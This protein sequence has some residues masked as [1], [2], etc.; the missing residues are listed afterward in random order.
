VGAIAAARAGLIFLWDALR[1][2]AV[3]MGRSSDRRSKGAGPS[4]GVR[5]AVAGALLLGAGVLAAGCED[6]HALSPADAAADSG[7]G[8]GAPGADAAGADGAGSP[9]GAAADAGGTADA[10]AADGADAPSGPDAGADAV[11]E[12]GMGGGDVAPGSIVWPPS[13]TK[14]V[15]E[16]R[17]GGFGP[18]A[19]AGS[20]CRYVGAGTFT[21]TIDDQQL[22]WQICQSGGAAAPAAPYTLTQGKRALGDV[23]FDRLIAALVKL[24]VSSRMI[25]GAD[26]QELALRVTTPAG[27]SEYLDSFYSCQKRGV[28]VDDIDS[29]FTIVRMLAK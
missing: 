20:Q 27:E 6:D 18:A 1:L 25:C 16:D 23:D 26:K 10:R 24:R 11:A 8:G 29:I 15:A 7:G 28:Y 3:P 5:L 2:G 17:G 19:P 22:A 14:L 4:I 21:L 9:D 13:A 12:A